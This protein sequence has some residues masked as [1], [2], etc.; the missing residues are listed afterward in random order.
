MKHECI[1]TQTSIDATA[2]VQEW[3]ARV[4]ST[5]D[6]ETQPT[7]ETYF[8]RKLYAPTP[9]GAAM[10]ALSAGLVNAPTFLVRLTSDRA[11]VEWTDGE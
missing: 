3:E 4:R 8:Q 2:P 7:E 10:A 9:L 6:N 5:P 11:T 1:V